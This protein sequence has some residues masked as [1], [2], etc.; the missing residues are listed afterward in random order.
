MQVGKFTACVIDVSVFTGIFILKSLSITHYSQSKRAISP[1]MDHYLSLME[2][3]RI[4]FFC[5]MSFSRCYKSN[6][7]DL[8]SARNTCAAS[9]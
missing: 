9:V 2:V 7:F 8:T 3:Y 5:L 1:V 4:V 6:C